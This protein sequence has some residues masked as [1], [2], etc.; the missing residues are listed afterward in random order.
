MNRL[1]R[2]RESLERRI[3]RL[4]EIP[5]GPAGWIAGFLSIVAVRHLLEIRSAGYPLYPPSAFYVHYVLAYLA[6]LLLL[7]LVLALF[8]AVRLERVLRLMLLAWGLTLLPPLVDSLVAR[9][10]EA[11]IGYM[12]LGDTPWLTVFV[13]FFDPTYPLKGT[14]P[15]IRVEAAAACLLGFT[16]T[17]LRAPAKRALRALGAALSVYLASLFVFT[18]PHLV[19]RALGAVFPGLSGVSLYTAVGRV[20]RPDPSDVRA[21]QGVLLY[22]VPLTLALAAVALALARPVLLRRIARVVARSEGWGWAVLASLGSY[23]GWRI[24]EGVPKAGMGAAPFDFLA[25]AG[26]PLS[27]VLIGGGLAWLAPVGSREQGAGA[28]LLAAGAIMAAAAS[29]EFAAFAAIALGAGVLARGIPRA[30]PW[31]ILAPQIASGIAALASFLAGYALLAGDEATI[32]LPSSLYLLAF[33]MGVLADLPRRR[34]FD[35]RLAPR[36][37]GRLS[38][39]ALAAVPLLALV[40]PA[41][42]LRAQV[43]A[44]GIVV[45]VLF[46][47]AALAATQFLSP[48]LAAAGSLLGAAIVLATSLSD[49][50][51]TA[52]WRAKALASPTYFFRLG[53]RAEEAGDIDAAAGALNE[54]LRRDPDMAGAHQRLGLIRFKR[55]DHEGAIASLEQAIALDPDDEELKGNLAAALLKAGRVD[56]ALATVEDALRRDPELPNLHFIRAQC[57]DRLGRRSEADA[58]WRTYILR[59]QGLVEEAGYVEAARR[60]LTGQASP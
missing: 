55:G 53:I 22:L 37:L 28:A 30:L 47:L 39:L 6:P 19:A 58:A 60:R 20:P 36:W 5:V 11:K 18:L 34:L 23:A 56:E 1:A 45:A 38:P 2:L 48:R 29:V 59:A 44:K 17:L 35:P 12:E 24:L 16:Y 27:L 43:P 4:E 52:V 41:A 15:G 57:L 7:S 40:V 31:A 50:G 14:T 46:S 42:A 25:L 8:S 49:P 51:K 3:E 21:D 32:L 54:A 10:H 9:A 33:F 13:H 26:G